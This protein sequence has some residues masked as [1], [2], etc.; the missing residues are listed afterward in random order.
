METEQKAEKS[1]A[2]TSWVIQPSVIVPLAIFMV[3]LWTLSQEV[4]FYAYFSI[5]LYFISLNPTIVLSTFGIQIVGI[6]IAL[7]LVSM[8]S[9]MIYLGSLFA[10][11]TPTRRFLSTMAVACFTLAISLI[12]FNTGN[13]KLAIMV[14]V[15]IVLLLILI[16][17][18]PLCIRYKEGSYWDNLTSLMQPREEISTLDLSLAARY[19]DYILLVIIAISIGFGGL[20]FGYLGY[21]NAQTQPWFQTIKQYESQEVVVIRSYGDYLLAVPFNRNTKQFE[22]KMFIMKISDMAKTPLSYE[23]VGPLQVK[24]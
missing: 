1:L 18:K 22:R 3:Y 17:L 6:S 10:A 20:F 2:V 12:L 4:G 24:P 5:P 8:I 16:F 9:F 7:L 15:P 19:W 13:T 21:S 14:G 23:K 11:K